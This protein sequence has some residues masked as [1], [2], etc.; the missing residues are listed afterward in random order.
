MA[1]DLIRLSGMVDLDW[2]INVI[3]S[4]EVNAFVLPGNFSLINQ[5]PLIFFVS[6]GG[7]IFVFTGL[8]P[9][10]KNEDGLATVLGHEMAHQIARHSAEK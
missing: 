4:P 10:A 8:L 7:K 1:E 3:N 6:K 2:E 5:I 9:V